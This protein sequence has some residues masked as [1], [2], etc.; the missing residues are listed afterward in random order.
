MIACGVTSVFFILEWVAIEWLIPVNKE[1]SR[2]EVNTSGR[3]NTKT[4][5]GLAD[6]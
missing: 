2:N 4:E 5:M 3:K 1:R 6:D